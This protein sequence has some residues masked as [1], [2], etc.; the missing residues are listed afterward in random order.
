MPYR[1]KEA[2]MQAKPSLS[3][4][5]HRF[6]EYALAEYSQCL[7]GK[8]ASQLMFMY[9]RA[10]EKSSPVILELGTAKGQAT[11]VFLQA[12]EETLGRLVSVDIVDCSDISYSSK[13]QFLQSNS[14]NVGFILSKAPYLKDGIDILYIDSKHSRSHVE[15]ELTSWYPYMN[16]RSWIFFD[17]VD[18]NPYRKGNRKDDATAEVNW[19]EIHEYVKSFFYANEDSLYLD[20]MYGS[21]GLACLYKLSSKGTTPSKARPIVHRKKNIWRRGRNWAAFL[22]RCVWR[23]L[24][25]T[26]AAASSIKFRF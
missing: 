10:M 16:E 2:R 18:S 20:I 21:T 6:E 13:W 7:D 23:T 25:F 12:C 15:K 17:D 8:N 5:F 11:T 24:P 19:D 22:A 1:G 14:L 9:R 26:R 3:T 4:K